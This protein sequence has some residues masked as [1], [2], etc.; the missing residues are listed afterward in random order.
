MLRRS[1]CE[2]R[3]S[4][5]RSGLVDLIVNRFTSVPRVEGLNPRDANHFFYKKGKAKRRTKCEAKNK[6][7]AKQRT[8]REVERGTNV[9]R[10][11]KREAKNELLLVYI[12]LIIIHSI[13]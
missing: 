8:I 10:R 5:G 13:N 9:K 1:K 12:A 3:L 2:K 7:E 4:R 6:C 11:T